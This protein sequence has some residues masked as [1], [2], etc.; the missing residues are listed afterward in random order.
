[1][2]YCLL[3]K[4]TVK[5]NENEFLSGFNFPKDGLDGLIVLRH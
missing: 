4:A 2:N 1:M 5:L 3:K